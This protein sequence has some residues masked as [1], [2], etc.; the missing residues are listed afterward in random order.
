MYATSPTYVK[1]IS[2]IIKTYNLTKYDSIKSVDDLAKEVIDGKWSTG[3]DRKKKL[4][5][6]GYDYNVVQ[7]MVNSLVLGIKK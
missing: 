1:T 6:A 5:A 7:R 2:T 3:V 4:E